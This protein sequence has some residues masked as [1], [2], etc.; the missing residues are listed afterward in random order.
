[1]ALFLLKTYDIEEANT[2]DGDAR[3]IQ[4][5]LPTARIRTFFKAGEKLGLFLDSENERRFIIEPI[6][7]G[8]EK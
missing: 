6:P 8:S 2:T 3:T 4:V 1:M 7:N 5:N